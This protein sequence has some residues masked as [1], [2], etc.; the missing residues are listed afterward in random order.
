M[1][2]DKVVE[3]DA[4]PE[5]KV[6]ASTDMAQASAELGS[7]APSTIAVPGALVV[8][9]PFSVDPAKMAQG[10]AKVDTTEAR[11]LELEEDSARAR[12]VLRGIVEALREHTPL[13]PAA[14][15]DLLTYLRGE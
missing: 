15:A 12:I 4:G 10:S 11:L 13:G 1:A 9:K 8:G 7:A 6:N 5:T 3:A 2:K 14:A